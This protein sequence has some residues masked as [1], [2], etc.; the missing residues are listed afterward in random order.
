ML[1]S[2]GSF[3]PGRPATAAAETSRCRFYTMS[4]VDKQLENVRE[5]IDE[6]VPRHITVSDV[7]YE[8]PELVIYTRDPREFAT[9]G[10]LQGGAA[11]D[12][13]RIKIVDTATDETIYDNGSKTPLGG[14]NIIVHEG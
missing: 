7:T 11:E 2:G 13:F 3:G 5:T 6:E 8:G 14:G 4:T 12:A 10:D 9:D 1:A